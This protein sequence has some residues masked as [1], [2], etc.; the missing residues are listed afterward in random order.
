VDNLLYYLEPHVELN[1]SLFRFATLRSHILPEIKG[2][3]EY[4]PSLKV[5]IIVG[6]H[7]AKECLDQKLDLH[8]AELIVLKDAKINKV[9][10]GYYKASEIWYNNNYNAEQLNSQVHLIK[11]SL[12]DF[13]PDA[14]LTYESA[15]PFLKSAYPDAV[16]FNT[17]FGM[18]SRAP[19]PAFGILDPCGLYKHSFQSRFQTEIQNYEIA[20]DEQEVL[21]LL[22]Q[23]AIKSLAQ[24]MP[25]KHFIE[26]VRE[27]F[28]KTLLL[29]CQIDGYFAYNECTEFVNQF[30]MVNHVLS[31]TPE[32]YGVIVTEHGYKRQISKEQVFELKNKYR[33]FIYFDNFNEDKIP[34]PSQFMIPYLDGVLSVS[35]SIAY[36][37][38]LWQKPF[39]ALGQSQMN[40]LSVS[41]SISD[42]MDYLKVNNESN[43]D[44]V[45]YYLLSHVHLSHRFDI[46]NGEQYYK[47]IVDLIH[48]YKKN[49]TSFKLFERRFSADE[50]K[51]R[52]IESNRNWLLV[53]EMKKSNAK[54]EPDELRVSMA[55]N[56]AIS[57][58]LFDTLAERDF[59]EPHELFLYIE[60]K[61]QRYLNNRNFKF[62]YF[63]CQAEADT[64]RPTRGEFEV[65]LDEIYLKFSEITGLNS[66]QT[67]FIQQAEVDAEIALIKVKRF[68][69]KEYDF[70]KLLCNSRTIISDIY[71]EQD[72]IEKILNNI[73]VTEYDH[74]LVSATTKTRK[75]NGSLYP[76]YLQWLEE[77]FQIPANKALHV[78]D[79]DHADGKMAEKNGLNTY[80]LPKAMD[81][82]KTSKI[83]DVL[84][85]TFVTKGISTSV[86]H[87][88]FSNRFYSAN[89][90]RTHQKSVFNSEPYNYGYI[91]L[92]PMVLGFVQWLY[93]KAKTQGISDLY[94]LARDG[95]ILKK[96]YDEYYK[97]VE[98]APKSHYLYCSR[99]AVM[100][101]SIENEE[102]IIELASQSFN[103]RSITDFL[104]SRFGIDTKLVNSRTWKKHAYKPSDIV[105]PYH[106]QKRFISF[107]KDIK[108][109]ILDKASQERKSYI[110]YLDSMGFIESAENGKPAVV[111]IGYS[112]SM[113]YYLKKML[114]L[115]KLPG[116][117]FL[118]HHHSRDH[119]TEEIF[120]GYLQDLD[121][122]RIAYRH[123][124]N[125]HI[126]IFES[127]LSSPEGS[128]VS[129]DGVGDERKLILLDAE[130]EI[131]RQY[132][133]KAIHAGA[134]DFASD[135]TTRFGNYRFEFEIPPLL[136]TQIIFNFAN[137]PSGLDAAMFADFEVENLF[138]GGSIWL[139]PEPPKSAYCKKGKLKKSVVDSMVDK[140][141]W[142]RGAIAYYAWIDRGRP[143]GQSTDIDTLDKPKVRSKTQLP[144]RGDRSRLDRKRSKLR[145]DPYSFFE[146]AKLPPFRQLKYVFK[147]NTRVGE[148]MTKAL[149]KVI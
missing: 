106:D 77:C 133:V 3:K 89:W 42:F 137:H 59:A 103:A 6:E 76:E 94:F 43:V 66:R 7:V 117:Y 47:L 88:L 17:M 54:I 60:P 97:N 93:R 62:H 118:T 13:I 49:G 64:R 122:H 29:A 120:E 24:N 2:L 25:L 102:D 85:A 104:E 33:N 129:I 22:R 63:R 91:A 5:K 86:L 96:V 127:A 56:D 50:I 113:Q 65:T 68:M 123:P 32:N 14:T 71:L 36:Q 125:D 27:Q 147:H 83:A 74:L 70:S 126:F 19:F 45:L 75:H 44:H 38:A 112:G 136:S 148:L 79:N 124:L 109:L 72:V 35:S 92:G 144:A 82:Y 95:W 115:E 26:S 4:K 98:G 149:R 39:C 53:E 143:N 18:F 81:N 9:V 16:H 105:S 28:D 15:A 141:K 55:E 111:D 11:N 12:G 146:D 119:F 31:Q 131:R 114:G 110:D 139:L 130:E 138:G 30:E 132:L 80:V 84:R 48:S 145:R 101:P 46:F 135:F 90:A 128:L 20:E 140:S 34:F 142:K 107:L 1:D 21:R 61:I 52:I 58:D 40:V 41:N 10:N 23:I 87:G 78:G 51:E 37:S 73:G 134:F 67:K 57:F 99:R 108:H 69:K 116:F 121:D 100:L 8:G